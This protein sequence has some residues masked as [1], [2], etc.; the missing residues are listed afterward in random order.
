MYVCMLFLIIAT[1]YLNF[2]AKQAQFHLEFV[3]LIL[4]HPMLQINLKAL[5]E[6]P[7]L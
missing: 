4:S 1:A 7:N 6:K 5:T 2:P 3:N